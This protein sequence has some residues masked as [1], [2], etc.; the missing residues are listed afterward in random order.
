MS[1]LMKCLL[2]AVIA[3]SFCGLNFASAADRDRTKD[4]KRDGSCQ[5]YSIEHDSTAVIAAN[6]TKKQDRKRDRSCQSYTVQ[7][8]EGMTLAADK[9]RDRN[10]DKS[11]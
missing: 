8:D 9:K 4:R 5:K 1:K 7:E 3:V 6:G 2:L 11:C 10:R